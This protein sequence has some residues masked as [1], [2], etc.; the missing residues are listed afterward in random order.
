MLNEIAQALQFFFYRSGPFSTYS[1]L[2]SRLYKLGVLLLWQNTW[3]KQLNRKKDLF[4]LTVSGCQFTQAKHH[5]DKIRWSSRYFLNSG[6]AGSKQQQR[7]AQARHAPSND[8]LPSK[9]GFPKVSSTSPKAP[10]RGDQASDPWGILYS[11][12][13]SFKFT[14]GSMAMIRGYVSACLCFD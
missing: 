4:K 2:H 9:P 10:S 1:C 7:W 8:L 13:N 11:N 12:H 14:Y 5:S 6:Q 3:Q